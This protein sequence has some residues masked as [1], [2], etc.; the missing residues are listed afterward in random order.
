MACLMWGDFFVEFRLF[1]GFNCL[2]IPAFRFLQVLYLIEGV[3]KI[4]E[5]ASKILKQ[6]VKDS[7]LWNFKSAVL[8]ERTRISH[9]LRIPGNWRLKVAK[10][11]W[12]LGTL[13]LVCEMST[14]MG[15]EINLV[16]CQTIRYDGNGTLS[17]CKH[18]EVAVNTSFSNPSSR[19]PLS[20]KVLMVFCLCPQPNTVYWM[21]ASLCFIMNFSTCESFSSLVFLQYSSYLQFRGYFYLRISTQNSFLFSKHEKKCQTNCEQQLHSG[22]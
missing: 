8:A 4:A 11:F 22:Y 2:S 9:F 3:Q 5:I 16:T 6:L 1:G 14:G 19:I 12:R 10:Y 17:A 13:W 20:S 7:K 15:T 21:K 18:I